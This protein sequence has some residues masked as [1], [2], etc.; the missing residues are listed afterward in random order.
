MPAMMPRITAVARTAALATAA[1][2]SACA[3]YTPK[4]TV[5]ESLDAV[6]VRNGPPTGSYALPGGGQRLEYAR[7]PF[8]RHTW[9]IDVAA[10]GRVAGIEQ[11]LT[12]ARF[13]EITPGMSAD[14]LLLR[15][16]RPST[17][18]GGGWQGGQYWSYRYQATFCQW[19]VVGVTPDKRV[20]DAGMAPDP[21]CDD[22]DIPSIARH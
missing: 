17:V 6:Q 15:L 5:G 10:D 3:S 2:L 20:R 9:M 13:Y 1:A 14:E 4:A 18:S 8:G 19:F 12:E 11:V 22:D 16:G 21:L 7:G